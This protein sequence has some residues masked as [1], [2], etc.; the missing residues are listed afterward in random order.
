MDE[1][2]TPLRSVN[3]LS[4]VAERKAFLRSPLC[5]LLL[6]LFVSFAIFNTRA[7]VPFDLLP[8][9]SI[10]E[11]WHRITMRASTQQRL[12]NEQAIIAIYSYMNRYRF[13][14]KISKFSELD[15]SSNLKSSL[16]TIQHTTRLMPRESC[17]KTMN[18][19]LFPSAWTTI[20][21][22]LSRYSLTLS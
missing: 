15:A 7:L 6:V 19:S 14:F 17:Q 18:R 20:I 2:E 22:T 12:K 3:L 10:I 1:E 8:L 9:S 16:D 21:F 5:F 11:Y 4:P 13:K